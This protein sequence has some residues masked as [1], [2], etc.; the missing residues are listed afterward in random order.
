MLKILVVEDDK[1]FADTLKHLIELNPRYTVTESPMMARR[2]WPQWRHGRPDLALVDLRLAR[3]RLVS[4]L[5]RSSANSDSLSVHDRQCAV[6]SLPDWRSA[7]SPSRSA[8]RI[9]F[10]R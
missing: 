3:G 7:A 10:A 9:W 1:L 2:R 5:Q 4:R 6:L 8:R